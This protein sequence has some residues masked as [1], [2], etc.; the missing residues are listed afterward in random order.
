MILTVLKHILGYPCPEIL[1][2]NP[3]WPVLEYPRK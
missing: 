3:H 1:K 2:A